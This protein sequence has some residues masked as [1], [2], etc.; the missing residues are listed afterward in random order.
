MKLKMKTRHLRPTMT[1]IRRVIYTFN[2]QNKIR[3]ER[4]LAESVHDF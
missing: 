4:C 3:R 1:K 2:F